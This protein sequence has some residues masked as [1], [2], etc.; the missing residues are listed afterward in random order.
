MGMKRVSSA[1][2][3]FDKS[4]IQAM[5]SSQ[6]SHKYQV[7]LKNALLY[8]INNGLTVRQRQILMMYYFEDLDQNEIA[9]ALEINKSTV[10]RTL[11]AA[12]GKIRQRLD[13][14]TKRNVYS[15]CEE[16]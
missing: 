5:Q 8:T 16:D 9:Q 7:L 15:S 3:E 14:L 1:A 11:K 12:R 2:L 13:F 6:T 10:S 4:F